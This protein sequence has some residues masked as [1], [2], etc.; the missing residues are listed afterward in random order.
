[1]GADYVVLVD[2]MGCHMV[3]PVR[4]LGGAAF[5]TPYLPEKAGQLLPD[6][7]ITGPCYIHGWFPLT[8]RMHSLFDL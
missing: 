3:R 1:M 6:G 5:A 7:K 2:H 4:W 8:P